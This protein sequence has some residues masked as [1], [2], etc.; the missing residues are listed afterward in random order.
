MAFVTI[1]KVGFKETPYR[2]CQGCER[3]L[4]SAYFPT[5]NEEA[6]PGIE[7]VKALTWGITRFR[8]SA[9]CDMCLDPKREAWFV[10][11]IAKIA[12][13]KAARRQ[14]LAELWGRY[15]LYHF[16]PSERRKLAV[17]RATPWWANERKILA[18]YERAKRKTFETGRQHHVDHIV[19][20][21]GG[22]V[23]GLHV[24]WNLRVVTA[25]AN[26][27]KGNKLVERL[28]LAP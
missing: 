23:C 28:A 10:E 8:R 16:R 9:L 14:Y 3:E 11:G 4:P 22:L 20:V 12:A 6:P 27:K 1:N 2:V 7:W 17:E 19:P 18:V 24:P 26:M 15:S 13:R 21:Q 5:V 25:K